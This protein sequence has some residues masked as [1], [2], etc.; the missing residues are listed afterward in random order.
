[1]SESDC[2]DSITSSSEEEVDND[3]EDDGLYEGMEPDEEEDDNE[4][5]VNDENAKKQ[6]EDLALSEQVMNDFE[7]YKE[8]PTFNKFIKHCGEDLRR[9]KGVIKSVST[10]NANKFLTAFS[11]FAKEV[12]PRLM[13]TYPDGFVE[14]NFSDANRVAFALTQEDAYH[15]T[16]KNLR[17]LLF[18]V[19]D[20]G[21]GSKVSVIPEWEG[22]S[23]GLYALLSDQMQKKLLQYPI[24]GL[25]CAALNRCIAAAR[26]LDS[27]SLYD[28]KSPK[29]F[30]NPD[31]TFQNTNPAECKFFEYLYDFLC[32]DKELGDPENHA[33]AYGLMMIG[34]FAVLPVKSPGDQKAAIMESELSKFLEVLR[35]VCSSEGEIW[36]VGLRAAVT[37]LI[38][39]SDFDVSLSIRFL[40]DFL[41]ITCLTLYILFTRIGRVRPIQVK[42]SKIQSISF[43]IF[44]ARI[45]TWKHRI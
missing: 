29:S 13:K 25:Y 30:E 19:M 3:D 20:M 15:Y 7:Y 45:T 14:N 37:M 43:E 41:K 11:N 27:N 9:R 17:H 40:S 22:L 4:K 16:F 42:S 23:C 39:N 21:R 32:A 8:D 12:I 34:L 6:E 24:P 35:V 18:V 2:N 26:S 1:M 28:P 36:R 44:L 5:D 33:G 31:Y 10:E 38:A